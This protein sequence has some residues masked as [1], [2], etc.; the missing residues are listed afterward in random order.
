LRH[1]A[2]QLGRDAGSSF[3]DDLDACIE[4][5]AEPT[6]LPVNAVP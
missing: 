6:N 2:V 5:L 4:P 3:V 1:V